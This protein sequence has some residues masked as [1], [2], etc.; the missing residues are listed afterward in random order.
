MSMCFILLNC[1]FFFYMS[2][3]DSDTKGCPSDSA[4]CRI[5]G[6]DKVGWGGPSKPL[7]LGQG[8]AKTLILEYSSPHAPAECSEN[9][10]VQ[11]LFNCPP[12]REVGNVHSILE[13]KQ[14]LYIMHVIK[15]YVIEIADL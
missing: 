2:S 1:F 14:Y 3:T 6:N 5:T 15:D 8:S 12:R 10:T 11:I 13:L 9:A 7:S 4:A